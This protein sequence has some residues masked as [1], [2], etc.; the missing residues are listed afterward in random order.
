MCLGRS[1]KAGTIKMNHPLPRLALRICAPLLVVCLLVAPLCAFWCS[2][3]S[4]KPF[5]SATTA[6]ENCQHSSG[7]HDRSGVDHLSSVSTCASSDFVLASPRVDSQTLISRISHDH[8]A[9]VSF[10]AF[11]VVS[12]HQVIGSP[13][14]EWERSSPTHKAFDLSL[15]APLRI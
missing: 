10:L 6:S 13:P 7:K 5:F 1:V 14:D 4:C 3:K 12:G 9:P 15:S 11:T 2:G 8:A